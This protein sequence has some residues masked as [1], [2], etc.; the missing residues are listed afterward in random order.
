M[1]S[2]WDGIRKKVFLIREAFGETGKT[3][4]RSARMASRVGLQIPRWRQSVCI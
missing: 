1:H 4:N 2:T 3:H